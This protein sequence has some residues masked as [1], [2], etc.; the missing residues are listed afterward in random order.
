M[1]NDPCQRKGCLR[2]SVTTQVNPLETIPLPRGLIVD[3]DGV[4]WHG[5]R[6]LPGLL[7]FFRFVARRG[8]RYLLATNNASRTPRQYRQKLARFGIEVAEEQILTSGVVT[9][10]YLAEIYP[11]AETRLFVIGEAG[12]LDPLKE[13]GFQ[14]IDGFDPENPA[15]LVVVGKDETLTWEKLALATLHLNDGAL[16][17]ATNGDTTLPT[18]RGFVHGNGAILAALTAATGIE[19]TIVGKPEP[20]IY[21]HALKRLDIRPEEALVVGDRLETDILGACRAG[22]PS[23]LLLSGVSDEEDLKKVAYRPTWVL[24][25]LE[26]L[27]RKL[28]ELL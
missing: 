3:M 6:P 21:Q 26:A 15:D 25:D 13:E 11:P 2:R 20:F 10:A 8:L 7:E 22:I 23:V 24:P 9:A 12:L 27:T 1:G 4:L 5:D 16:F 14:L 19:P 17:V 18:E 28:E